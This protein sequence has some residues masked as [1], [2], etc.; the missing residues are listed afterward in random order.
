LAKRQAVLKA[1][2]ERPRLLEMTRSGWRRGVEE[3]QQGNP[4]TV[5][6]G[7][8]NPGNKE[9]CVEEAGLPAVL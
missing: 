3:E 1:L 7:S 6:R 2:A 8:P 4:G 5:L 9:D